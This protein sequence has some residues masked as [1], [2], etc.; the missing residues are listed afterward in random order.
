MLIYE[1]NWYKEIEA[2]N[3][4]GKANSRQIEILADY[5]IDRSANFMRRLSFQ[6]SE[7][8][9]FFTATTLNF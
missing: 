5:R 4:R 6:H 7:I 1:T 3:G 2:Y 8:Y 9:F